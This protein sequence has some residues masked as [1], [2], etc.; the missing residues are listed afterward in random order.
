MKLDIARV[1]VS[2]FCSNIICWQQAGG[3]IVMDAD[4][5]AALHKIGVAATDD[6]FKFIWLKV[7]Y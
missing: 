2:Y 6:S 4:A 1:I 5:T 7:C 3:A